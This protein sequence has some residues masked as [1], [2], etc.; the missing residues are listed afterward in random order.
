[1]QRVYMTKGLP[2]SGKTTWAMEMVKNNTGSIKR[3]NKDDLRSMLD[4]GKYSPKNEKIILDTRDL[5]LTEY[6]VRGFSVI[7]DD[8][9]LAP[10]HKKKGTINH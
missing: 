3:I 4:G 9:N 7:I 6:L 5:L 10:E 8:T 1:M 2:G